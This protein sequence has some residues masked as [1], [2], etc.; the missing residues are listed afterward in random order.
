ML[1]V[2]SRILRCPSEHCVD[3]FDRASPHEGASDTRGTET[4]CS[5]K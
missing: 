3:L 1:V 4:D 2:S 5:V